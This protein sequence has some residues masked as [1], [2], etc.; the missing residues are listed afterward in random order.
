MCFFN[1]Q[2]EEVSRNFNPPRGGKISTEWEEV[3][4]RWIHGFTIVEQKCKKCG[5][6]VFTET[7]GNATINYEQK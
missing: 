4:E 7:I 5:K 3:F 6:V 1:H 2:L